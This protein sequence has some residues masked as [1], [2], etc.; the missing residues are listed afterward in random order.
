[1]SHTRRT[2][3]ASSA[4]I[5]AG[6]AAGAHA[7]GGFCLNESGKEG[8]LRLSCQEGVAPGRSLNE[9]LDFLEEHGFEG[10]E[11]GGGNLHKRVDEFQ[12][13]L[14]GRN[15]KVSAICAGFSGAPVSEFPEQRKRAMETM[16]VILEAAGALGSTGLIFVPAFNS[17]SQAGWV[18]ARF[19][20]IDFLQ[21][22][23]SHAE[24]V[25]CRLLLEP[26]N[27]TETWYVR[28]LADAAKIC[29]EVNHP[30]ICLMGDF[31]HMG[32]EEAC[33]YSAFLGARQWLHHVHLA[34][35]PH[36]KQPGYDENDDF[37]PGFR[38][39]KDIGYQDYC[40]FEC[41]IEGSA[42]GANNEETNEM[43]KRIEIPK[44]V[45]FLKRQW[46]EA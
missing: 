9:K 45:E 22:I 5:G 29:Q 33:E 3:L 41:G 36:R 24:K 14:S 35:R 11:P 19:L 26:L 8:V 18:S 39:L 27:R 31:Y 42:K 44:S 46:E 40:S 1:M 34:S 12:K 2:F 13:A 6:L 10:I 7:E 15:I 37:R 43:N 4:V 20:L 25:K 17:Q 23:A 21:E 32:R 28:Q 38:A 16:K 30:S